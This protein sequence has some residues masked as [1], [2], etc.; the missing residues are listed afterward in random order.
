MLLLRTRHRHCR[1]HKRCGA[2]R[3]GGLV[4]MC[5]RITRRNLRYGILGYHHWHHHHDLEKRVHL[6]DDSQRRYKMKVSFCYGSN[7]TSRQQQHQQQGQPTPQIK[8]DDE[9]NISLL[10]FSCNCGLLY[11]PPSIFPM[12]LYCATS[13]CNP[14]HSFRNSQFLR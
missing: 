9:D 8:I 4:L 6:K 12:A 13:L 14:S 11:P 7:P 3:G 5:R 1:G 2:S 10:T